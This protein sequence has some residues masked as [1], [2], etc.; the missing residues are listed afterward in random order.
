MF[1]VWMPVC[2]H[3]ACFVSTYGLSGAQGTGT[4]FLEGENVIAVAGTNSVGH[5]SH[6]GHGSRVDLHEICSQTM[7]IVAMIPRK[8]MYLSLLDGS[9]SLHRKRASYTDSDFMR[10]TRIFLHKSVLRK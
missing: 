7:D 10:K 2:P 6:V 5:G 8:P 3:E 9:E 4:I 1:D